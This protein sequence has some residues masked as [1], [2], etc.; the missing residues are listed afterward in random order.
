MKADLRI[1]IKDYRPSAPEASARQAVA[2]TSR[3]G[4]FVG[5]SPLRSAGCGHP[6]YNPV[7]TSLL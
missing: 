6:A 2:K 7:A 4:S 3:F 1:S 5:L